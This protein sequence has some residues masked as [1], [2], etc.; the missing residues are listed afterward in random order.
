MESLK[1]LSVNYIESEKKEY[2]IMNKSKDA[3]FSSFLDLNELVKSSF[4]DKIKNIQNQNNRLRNETKDL[5]NRV[6][7]LYYKVE[8]FS[9]SI[10]TIKNELIVDDLALDLDTLEIKLNCVKKT[11]NDIKE[12]DQ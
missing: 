9:L 4:I 2:E 3:F 8:R 12:M 6:F 5:Q 11:L 10:D 1:E 7:G